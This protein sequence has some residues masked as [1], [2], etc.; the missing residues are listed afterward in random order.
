MTHTI[1]G[2]ATTSPAEIALSA[3]QFAMDNSRINRAEFGVQPPE[4]LL[5]DHHWW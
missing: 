1:A 3:F 4:L 5:D 2:L